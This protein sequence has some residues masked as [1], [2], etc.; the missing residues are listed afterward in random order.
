MLDV[1]IPIGY[2][3]LIIGGLLLVYGFVDPQLT[4]L[5]LVGKNPGRLI[6]NLNLP[7]GAAML[8]FAAAMLALVRLDIYKSKEKTRRKAAIKAKRELEKAG[9]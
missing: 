8:I 2:L 5:E 4:N 6:L 3:F 9:K 1:R 7:C